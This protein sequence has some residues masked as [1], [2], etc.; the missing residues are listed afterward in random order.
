MVKLKELREALQSNDP[1]LIEEIYERIYDDYY[2]LV[3]DITNLY[4]S[5]DDSRKE[6]IENF[7]EQMNNIL[8]FVMEMFHKLF[9]I[10]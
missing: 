6:E 1:L 5:K 4:K 8:F 7:Q 2:K 10:Q 9:S 3:K